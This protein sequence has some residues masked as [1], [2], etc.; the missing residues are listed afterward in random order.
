MKLSLR[1]AW[2]VA[3]AVL[4]AAV[5]ACVGPVALVGVAGPLPVAHATTGTVITNQ[6]LTANTTWTTAGSPYWIQ[7]ELTINAGVRLTIEP[8]VVVKIGNPSDRYG[9]ISVNGQLIALGT[10]AAPVVFTSHRDDSIA[11]DTN[12]DGGATVPAR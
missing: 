8:G 11:G 12:G 10:S 3:S 7:N 1:R 4:G 9:R 5:A 6:T 2:K